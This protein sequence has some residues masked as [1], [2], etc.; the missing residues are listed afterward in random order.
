MFF[1]SFIYLSISLFLGTLFYSRS[2]SPLTLYLSSPAFVRCFSFSLFFSLHPPTLSFSAFPWGYG[3]HIRCSLSL[4]LSVS[5]SR[6]RSLS[7]SLSLSLSSTSCIFVSFCLSLSSAFLSLFHSSLFSPCLSF[8]DLS[9]SR[10]FYFSYTFISRF[11]FLPAFFL[12][13][14]FSLSL[15]FFSPSFFFAI[16]LVYF[17]LFSF[18]S[19]S[20]SSFLSFFL[21]TFLSSFFS[22]FALSFSRSFFFRSSLL[23]IFFS[24]SLPSLLSVSFLLSFLLSFYFLSFSPPPIQS[25][26]A[27]SPLSVCLSPLMY[28]TL[29]FYKD[30]LL[31]GES[32]IAHSDPFPTATIEIDSPTGSPRPQLGHQGPCNHR[33][34]KRPTF[35]DCPF[36]VRTDRIRFPFCGGPETAVAVV[37]RLPNENRELYFIAWVLFIFQELFPGGFHYFKSGRWGLGWGRGWGGGGGGDPGCHHN[38]SMCPNTDWRSSIL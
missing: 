15:S 11:L 38:L 28:F 10:S 8:L 26:Q 4:S 17:L 23:P 31:S 36:R 12:S 1:L 32:T 37:E 25:A 20:L 6:S 9:H 7:L 21:H 24:F 13:F 34:I 27:A 22:L 16:S 19:F 33:R 2:F 29:E 3:N 5:V 30:R 14:F 18:L 35:S